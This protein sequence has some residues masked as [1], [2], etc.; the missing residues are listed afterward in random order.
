MSS[1]SVATI[2]RD[3]VSLSISCVDRLYL[4]GYVPMLQAP[5]HIATFCR[6]QLNAPIPSPALFRPLLER[7]VH[8]VEAFAQQ[9]DVPIIH[10]SR[11]QKKDA[12]AEQQRAH[13]SADE[14]VVFI[15]IAQ[16]KA[17]SFKAH[18]NTTQPG[19]WFTFSRQPVYVNQYYFYLQDREWGPAF[20]KVGSYLPYPV[21]LCLNGHEWAKQQLR[22]RGLAF[23]SLDNGFRWCADPNRLQRI[24]DR[25]GPDDVQRFF[26]RWQQRLPWPLT[27]AD[28]AAGYNHRLTIWQLEVSLTDVFNAPL[29]GRQ[30]FET[31]IRDNLDLGRPGRVNL[32]FPTRMTRRTPPPRGGYHTR[33]ITT[34]VAPSLH[35]GYKHTDIKQYFKLGSAL[36]TETTINEPKDFQPTKALSTLCHLRTIGEQINTRLL[37]AEQ[38][39]HACRLS[40]SHFE[41][42]QQPIPLGTGR[43]SALRF[44]DPRVHAL[45]QA[46]SHFGHVPEGFQN[47]DLR[48]LVAA[49]LGRA[50][51]AYSRGAMTYDLRRLRLH[52]LLQRVAG[53]HRYLV[54]L[55]GW[56]VAGF[57]NTLYQHVLR[58]GWATLADS[59]THVPDQL[60]AALRKLAD[61]TR[62]LFTHIHPQHS[63]AA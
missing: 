39:N 60:S 37:E 13:F 6:Q 62:S 17:T 19:V 3:H 5:G 31:V 47:R 11:G 63:A 46:I 44:G 8:D 56:Q 43:V 24:C 35:V 27:R 54:T 53:T 16:E 42:L 57:Y 40:P 25:L 23:E 28:R 58:P 32:L 2:L 7:F 51:D 49:A 9:H 29:Y 1:P 20:I 18:K 41:R 45:L 12:I 14:G 36:R 33:I 10:F 59:Q 52:G 21:R 4:N 48:P 38:L 26:D 22:R 30:F 61:V 50:L 55:D 34:G 15:G